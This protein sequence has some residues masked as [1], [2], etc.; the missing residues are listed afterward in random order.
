MDTISDGELEV[1]LG[2]DTH[3]DQHAAAAL[4]QL[5]R[6]LGTTSVPAT[7]DGYEQL[8]DWASGFGLVTREN[9][10]LNWPTAIVHRFQGAPVLVRETSR[11]SLEAAGRLLIQAVIASRASWSSGTERVRPRLP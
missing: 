4:D 3:L 7:P 9:D 1:T 5:G 8:I 10:G 11:C 2:I 6:V